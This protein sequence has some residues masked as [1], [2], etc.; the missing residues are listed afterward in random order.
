MLFSI[1][2][3][4]VLRGYR[5]NTEAHDLQDIN[6]NKVESHN[7][8]EHN[9]LDLGVGISIE[10]ILVNNNLKIIPSLSAMYLRNLTET[11]EDQTVIFVGQ[12]YLVKNTATPK[13]KFEAKAELSL[14]YKRVNLS[15]KYAYS[16]MQYF[17][18]NN[19][20][21]TIKFLL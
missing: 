9:A 5:V 4:M 20:Y 2:P 17:Y 7:K 18:G 15:I 11:D 12:E 21:L 16:K 8:K 19:Y 1:K 13:N 6:N 10:S 14:D 3:K